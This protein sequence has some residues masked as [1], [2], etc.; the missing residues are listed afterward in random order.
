[1]A[2][3]LERLAVTHLLGLDTYQSSSVIDREEH[4]RERKGGKQDQDA[5]GE[6]DA[7]GR[8]AFGGGVHLLESVAG[9]RARSRGRRHGFRSALLS[10]VPDLG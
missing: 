3:A 8:V 2:K 9:V 6:D 10:A 1:M 7:D 5:E 4:A